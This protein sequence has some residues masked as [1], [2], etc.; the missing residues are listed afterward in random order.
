MTTAS[1]ERIRLGCR[2]LK[3]RHCRFRIVAASMP[4][5]NPCKRKTSMPR[6]LTKARELEKVE[7]RTARRQKDV[8]AL[9]SQKQ[10][11]K[12]E[13][14]NL[15]AHP[16]ARKCQGEPCRRLVLTSQQDPCKDVDFARFRLQS[17][18]D[19]LDEAQ[20]IL[21]SVR[22]FRDYLKKDLAEDGD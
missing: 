3:S 15:R 7:R 5:A 13:I 17:V 9:K 21:T 10:A 12:R 19:E 11:L 14:K 1:E 2:S 18:L 22:R 16:S 6:S 8:E 20:A 4:H